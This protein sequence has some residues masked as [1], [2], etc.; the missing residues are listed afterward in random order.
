MICLMLPSG[1]PS[2]AKFFCDVKGRD[3]G[4]RLVARRMLFLYSPY[5][6]EEVRDRKEQGDHNVNKHEDR[7]P[8]IALRQKNCPGLALAEFGKHFSQYHPEPE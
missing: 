7:F 8:Q 2:L 6:K 4:T 1:A 3:V 5:G